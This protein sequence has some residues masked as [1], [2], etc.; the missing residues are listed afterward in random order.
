M[1]CYD[2]MRNTIQSEITCS[3]A[4]LAEIVQGLIRVC[5]ANARK[6]KIPDV[7][8]HVAPHEMNRG[9]HIDTQGIADCELKW[10]GSELFQRVYV[11]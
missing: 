1:G 7:I 8:C 3:I 5:V 6:S 9:V 4:F 11:C 10:I 2:L